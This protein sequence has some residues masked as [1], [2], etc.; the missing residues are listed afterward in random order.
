MPISLEWTARSTSSMLSPVQMDTAMET[1]WLLGSW[2]AGR[3]LTERC[4][5]IF[6]YALKFLFAVLNFNIFF[7]AHVGMY[8]A[9]DDITTTIGSLYSKCSV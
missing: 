8:L 7:I 3:F 9:L 1:F 6:K 5:L 2:N 4:C